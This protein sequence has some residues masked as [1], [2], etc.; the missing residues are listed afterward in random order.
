M[1][2]H[3]YDYRSNLEASEKVNWKIEDV[4]GGRT[5]DFSSRSCR[6]RSRA[7]TASAA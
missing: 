2:N 5:L 3:G 6:R 4:I 1:L 7:W